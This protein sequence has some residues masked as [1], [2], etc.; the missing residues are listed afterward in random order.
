MRP[1]SVTANTFSDNRGIL[2]ELWTSEFKELSPVQQVWKLW[3]LFQ[4]HVS[5]DKQ[6]SEQL[7]NMVRAAISF[8]SGTKT[9]TEEEVIKL[10]YFEFEL[11]GR[12][13]R[14]KIALARFEIV[15]GKSYDNLPEDR[16]E[17]L[18]ESGVDRKMYI[19]Q[20]IR[21]IYKHFSGVPN[22]VIN[23]LMEHYN[24]QYDAHIFLKAFNANE[25]DADENFFDIC[26]SNW[27]TPD[28]FTHI[29]D[30]FPFL[31]INTRK[32]EKEMLYEADDTWRLTGN[33]LDRTNTSDVDLE[34]DSRNGF[35][36]P[37]WFLYDIDV[38]SA[39]KLWWAEKTKYIFWRYFLT[40]I[41]NM[42]IAQDL[43]MPEFYNFGLFRIKIDEDTE[44]I[45][46]KLVDIAQHISEW[47]L[48][49]NFTQAELSMLVKWLRGV[50]SDF[51]TSWEPR[52]FDHPIQ[53]R[54]GT[55][56]YS[57][58]FSG[59]KWYENT[60]IID[61]QP[62]DK[63]GKRVLRFATELGQDTTLFVIIQTSYFLKHKKLL[64]AHIVWREIY[65]MYNR[66]SLDGVERF[67]P[68]SMKEQYDTMVQ[69]VIWPLSA[70]HKKKK[71]VIWKPHN[72]LLYWVYG[73][74]KSQLL[75]HLIAER[76]YVL[77]NGE[78]I[79][80]EAN[81][82]NIWIMEFTDL[83]VKSISGFRKRLSDIHENTWRPIILVIEDIDTIIKEQ[84]LESD[85]VSQAMTTLFEWVW[86][87]P[88]TVIA[89]TNNPEILPQRHLRPNRI[90]TL[91]SFPYPIEEPLL[92]SILQ[93]HWEK[94]WLHKMIW[95]VLDLAQVE[96]SILER[97]KHYT[98]SHIS[99]L[100]RGIYEA[101]EFE[102]I[103]QLWASWIWNVIK[104]EI[105]DCLVPLSDMQEREKCMI[106]WR[107]KLWSKGNWF[108]FIHTGSSHI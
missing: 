3:K 84:W 46:K 37:N 96:S 43:H 55:K 98:A 71:G 4:A 108:G 83:L 87:L 63:N 24:F 10:S 65:E 2:W 35:I 60:H 42:W 59:S 103:K 66:L 68:S 23:S 25:V 88:I 90:D 45:K 78:E 99:A 58:Y 39:L 70:E 67:D 15:I 28:I 9:L 17:E 93:V 92:R 8:A 22:E 47:E 54:P 72:M 20:Q 32:I 34:I 73:T 53:T 79:H 86:S 21:D 104:K 77:R 91:V 101:L 64:P 44:G 107:S 14:K 49:D 52:K 85:P 62:Q 7:M 12:L 102:D 48:P 81:V 89:S 11:L 94:K 38:D 69:K 74:G 19:K 18:S 106:Q 31:W 33:Y 40:G 6:L 16:K 5:W 41:N 36:N 97:I 50:I 51:Q 29:W 61:I 13:S 82:I 1:I 80:L 26:T 30:R 75:T 100:C 57:G 95:D 56:R 27:L 105:D 76:K